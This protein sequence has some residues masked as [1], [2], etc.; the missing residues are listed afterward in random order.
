VTVISALAAFDVVY[1]MTGG[2]PGTTTIVPGLA[3]YQ[4][5]FSQ[6]QVGLAASIGIVL[7]LLVYAVVLAINFVSRERPDV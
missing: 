7:S 6:N 4:L 3:I 1:I 2:G 5:A